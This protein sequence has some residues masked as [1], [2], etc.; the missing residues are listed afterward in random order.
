MKD[1]TWNNMK[2]SIVSPS[3]SLMASNGLVP[4]HRGKVE[5][6]LKSRPSVWFCLTTM[7]FEHAGQRLSGEAVLVEGRAATDDGREEPEGLEAPLGVSLGVTESHISA[8]WLARR[9][10]HRAPH[11][12]HILNR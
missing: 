3:P 1:E 10:F 5:Q 6:P 7:G 11:V 2:A 12:S 9:S 4:R 8:P